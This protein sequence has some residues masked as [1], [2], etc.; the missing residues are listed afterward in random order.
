MIQNIQSITPGKAQELIKAMTPKLEAHAANIEAAKEQKHEEGRN[1]E[2]EF[3]EAVGKHDFEK[4]GKL[5]EEGY[6]PSEEFIKGIGKEHGLD[7]GKPMKSSSCS[8]PSRKNRANMKG[9]PHVCWMPH[10]PTTFMS[11]KRYRKK[12]TG[13]PK[14]TLP[15]CVKRVCKPTR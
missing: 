4:I 7:E 13:S 11:S 8:A 3:K 2:A 12:G 1:M 10:R 9:R 14:K 15:R 5:K 6:K